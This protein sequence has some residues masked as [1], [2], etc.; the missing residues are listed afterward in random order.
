MERI[1][2][3][4]KS[5][6]ISVLV[7]FCHSEDLACLVLFL[8]VLNLLS[9]KNVLL[10]FGCFFLF[11]ACT[12]QI[13]PVSSDDDSNVSSGETTDDASTYVPGNGELF[14]CQGRPA[15]NAFLCPGDDRNLTTDVDYSAVSACTEERK[16]EV[17]CRTGYVFED[18]ACV[19]DRNATDI[20]EATGGAQCYYI[21]P[22][23]DD[24]NDGSLAHPFAST[25]PI[26]DIISAG[27]F[28]YF[29]DGSY[30]ERA[31]GQIV[32]YANWLPDHYAVAYI[33]RDGEENRPITFKAYPGEQP[34][35]DL[36]E[37]NPAC[38]PDSLDDCANDAFHVRGADYI[39]IE[40]MEIVH[41][42]IFVGGNSQYTWIENN[43]V[44]DLYTDRDNNGLIML[45]F[46]Q[47]AYVRNNVLHD[48]YSRSIPDGDGGWKFNATKE[49]YDAQHNGCITTLSG[50]GYVGYGNETSGP[51]EFTSN[52]IYDCP[53][54]LFMKNSQGQM[55]NE[56]GINIL[57]KDNYFHG[58]GRLAQW[59][60]AANVVFENNLFK[61]IEG[62]SAL[63]KGE[64]FEEG[65]DLSML[66]EI[67][68]R[69]VQFRHNVFT[70]TSSVVA[71]HGQGF[72][73]ENGV[74]ST[75]LADKFKFYNNVVMLSAAASPGSMG[76]NE[77]GFIFGNSYAGMIDDDPSRSKTLSRI[78]SQN[79]CFVNERGEN[80]AFLKHWFN[81][82]D[83]ITGYSHAE[84]QSEFGINGDGDIFP[85]ETNPSVH[86]NDPENYDY[87]IKDG[88]PCSE[89][90]HVGLLNP[91]LFSRRGEL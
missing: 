36:Y 45:Y 25:N 13:G 57:I 42:S 49:H 67:S 3:D 33:R 32:N 11:T 61:D 2:T 4:K 24:S 68:A 19:F 90:E 65:G 1:E 41:G 46:T 9:K 38:V 12:S 40:G 39:R 52:D 18:G 44:H 83:S 79:N 8:C 10:V 50:D 62:I 26:I 17:Q 23:G 85:T 30:G 80:V 5:N 29:R 43:H 78:N 6:E 21:A 88:S 77:G 54:H 31:Q 75:A 71:M 89:I 82:S 27:D 22:D 63:G 81:G 87:S 7:R 48:T 16:C 76:W 69:N 56:D 35:F 51:F 66:N 15:E 64:Q 70:S 20:C 84:S 73:L 86:F 58:E 28:I 74:Y 37:I 34:V 53:V 91:G 72:L 14:S 55:V 47:Y 60:E 59:F